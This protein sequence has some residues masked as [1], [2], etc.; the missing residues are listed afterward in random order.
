[1]Y[2]SRKEKRKSEI[3]RQGEREERRICGAVDRSARRIVVTN[4]LR[5]MEEKG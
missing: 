2:T 1:M 4:F 3:M 5:A